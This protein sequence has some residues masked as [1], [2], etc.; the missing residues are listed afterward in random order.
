MLSNDV[1]NLLK[2]QHYSLVGKHSAVQICRWTKKSLKDEG[3]CYKEKWYGIKSH[4]CMEFTPSVIWCDHHCLWCWRLQTGD[5]KEL[6]WQEFPFDSKVDNPSEILDKAIEARKK[7]LTGFG[8]N[9]KVDKKKFEEALDPK[10]IAISLSGEPT[11]YPK[12]S[13]LIDEC[14]KR[15]I[16][17]FLVTNGTTPEILKKITISELA[18]STESK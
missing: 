14:H 4:R 13:E 2:K 17:T 18:M 1:K 3:V 7:L 16:Y 10:N 15:G 11:L 12:I 5:R 9:N 8:G 6:E